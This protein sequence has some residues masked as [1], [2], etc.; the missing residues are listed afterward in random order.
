MKNEAPSH[1]DSYRES[2]R[3]FRALSHPARVQ[4]LNE[5]RGKGA[6]VGHLQAVL[7]RPQPYISQQLRVLR[8]AGFAATRR[9]GVYIYYHVADPRIERLLEIFFGPAPLSCGECECECPD[10]RAAGSTIQ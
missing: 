8:E 6:C 4:I 1:T 10:C 9:D 5:L 3:M 7:R 2:A